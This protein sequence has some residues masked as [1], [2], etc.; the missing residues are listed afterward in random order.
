MLSVTY[1]LDPGEHGDPFSATVR[2]SGRRAEATGKSQ[3]G[4]M[5]SQEETVE[6]IVPGSGPVA[7]TAEVRD[8][9]P[10]RWTVTARPV[11]RAGGGAARHRRP[12]ARPAP[13]RCRGHGGWRSRPIPGRAS[14]PPR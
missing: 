3:P 2:F 11:S 10:G 7:I 8:I 5:F 9:N 13:G 4:D 12:G 6:G 1:W 14:T